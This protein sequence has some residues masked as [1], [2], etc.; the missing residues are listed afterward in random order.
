MSESI[1]EQ[2][3]KMPGVKEIHMAGN[4]TIVVVF[5]QPIKSAQIKEIDDY[6]KN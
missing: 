4:Q 6:R 1:I 3:K 2:I 5:N